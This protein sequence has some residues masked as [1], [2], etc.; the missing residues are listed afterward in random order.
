VWYIVSIL[1]FLT[2]LNEWHNDN[3]SYVTHRQPSL[4]FQKNTYDNVIS[5]RQYITGFIYFWLFGGCVTCTHYHLNMI[6]T[7]SINTY[8]VFEF[9]TLSSGCSCFQLLICGTETCHQ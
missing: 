4:F 6:T 8:N 5:K 3:L 1:L 9:G 7:S 2:H